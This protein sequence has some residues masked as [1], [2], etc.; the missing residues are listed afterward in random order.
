M[1]RRG[2]PARGTSATV[3]TLRE[4]DLGLRQ[5]LLDLLFARDAE[6]LVRWCKVRSWIDNALAGDAAPELATMELAMA[7]LEERASLA[8]GSRGADDAPEQ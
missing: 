4:F 1:T 7:Y 6:A 5:L 2:L 8:R 3:L